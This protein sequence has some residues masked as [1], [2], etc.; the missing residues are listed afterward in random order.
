M[1]VIPKVGGSIPFSHPFSKCFPHKH[2]QELSLLRPSLLCPIW[3]HFGTKIGYKFDANCILGALQLIGLVPEYLEELVDGRIA[4]P[5]RIECFF[6]WGRASYKLKMGDDTIPVL[7]D[8][9]RTPGH[10]KLF[11]FQL[12]GS[13]RVVA[14][15]LGPIATEMT[16]DGELLTSFHP[17]VSTSGMKNGWRT[18]PLQVATIHYQAEELPLVCSVY[19]GIASNHYRILSPSGSRMC[20]WKKRAGWGTGNATLLMSVRVPSNFLP[21]A[22][23]AMLVSLL[24]D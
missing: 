4:V 15:R 17:I 3:N 7:Q 1:I 23:S 18:Y 19:G 20:F 13:G 21:L 11:E 8:L 16:L 6:N 10:G 5:R 14:S 24:D 9:I 22:I 12:A 2:L